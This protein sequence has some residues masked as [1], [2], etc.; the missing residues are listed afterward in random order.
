MT[1]EP[2]VPVRLE[3]TAAEITY[4]AF[5]AELEVPASLLNADRDGEYPELAEWL[6]QN[7]DLWQGHIDPSK[8]MQDSA[9][10]E[11]IAVDI[12]RDAAG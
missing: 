10:L 9:A 8:H 3:L 6:D 5:P 1:T 12:S 4:F 11:V 7:P 2:H